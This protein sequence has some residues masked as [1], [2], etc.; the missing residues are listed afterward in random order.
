MNHHQ[1]TNK[2]TNHLDVSDKLPVS[3]EPCLRVRN[4]SLQACLSFVIF[5]YQSF[6]ALEKL[7]SMAIQLLLQFPF[8]TEVNPTPSRDGGGTLLNLT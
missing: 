6:G 1:M 2:F 7:Y 5:P 4:S 3:H 8:R